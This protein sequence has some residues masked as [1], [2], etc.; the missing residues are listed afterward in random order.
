[1]RRVIDEAGYAAAEERIQQ[2]DE[3]YAKHAARVMDNL[4]TADE[5]RNAKVWDLESLNRAE[6]RRRLFFVKLAFDSGEGRRLDREMAGII[7]DLDAATEPE[8]V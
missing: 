2:F 5:V 6:E 4:K 8:D 7:A 3:A 1:M